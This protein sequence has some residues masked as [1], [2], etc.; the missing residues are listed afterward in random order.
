MDL[1]ESG[2]CSE[3][4]PPFSTRGVLVGPGIRAVRDVRFR[5]GILAQRVQD[6]L[7]DAAS[8]PS[9]EPVVNRLPRA[10]PWRQIAPRRASL[11]D[12]QNRIEE[13]PHR[14]CRPAASAPLGR[15]QRL[16]PLPLLIVQ[17]VTVHPEVGS[18]CDL[19]RNPDLHRLRS[20]RFAAAARTASRGSGSEF[21][22]WSVLGTGPSWLRCEA[23]AQGSVN[24]GSLP[25]SGF[26]MRLLIGVRF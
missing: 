6:A 25:L 15:K 11:C 7:Q 24:L 18:K 8:V 20:P 19:A 1:R 13:L 9:R 21:P 23:L 10:E 5:I 22:A 17:L 3:I 4:G 16:K 2:Q 12:V 14:H 26:A